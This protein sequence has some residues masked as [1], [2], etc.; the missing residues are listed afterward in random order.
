ME[1]SDTSCRFVTVFC[2][3]EVVVYLFN[4]S[5]RGKA[6]GG[7]GALENW[8]TKIAVFLLITLT[9]IRRGILDKKKTEIGKQDCRLSTSRGESFCSS[10]ETATVRVNITEPVA[11]LD[12]PCTQG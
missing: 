6:S 8:R 9:V 12:C 11:R 1:C 2:K 4:G 3:N 10:Y 7:T 5:T